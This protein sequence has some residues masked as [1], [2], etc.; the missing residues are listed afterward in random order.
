VIQECNKER[1]FAQDF[2]VTDNEMPQTPVLPLVNPAGYARVHRVLRHI[3]EG[4]DE[5]T[6]V[7]NDFGEKP[8][9]PYMSVGEMF[10]VPC[11]CEDAQYPLHNARQGLSLFRADYEMDVVAH[12][13]KIMDLKTELFLC[14]LDGGKK[15][16][17]HGIAMEDHLFSVC[18]GGDVVRGAGFKD[19]ISPH[20]GFMAPGRKML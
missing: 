2:P 20:T 9:S 14:P 17:P 6:H 10:P 13:A 4:F 5:F 16:G 15:K 12:N 1:Q 11:H 7:V 3:G 18:P 19:S 8:L